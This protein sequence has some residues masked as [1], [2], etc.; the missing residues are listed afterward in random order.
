MRSSNSYP[1]LP[2]SGR[3]LVGGAI[4]LVV[5][6]HW[7]RRDGKAGAHAGTRGGGT[8]PAV[9]RRDDNVAIA[10]FDQRLT[11]DQELLGAFHDDPEFHEF[12]E[13]AAVGRRRR[14]NA[15]APDH[16]RRVVFVAHEATGLSTFDDVFLPVEV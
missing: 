5:R 4:S 3:S 6:A 13:V 16:V 9:D 8:M 12:V 11:L 2:W 7:T 14:R 10:G 1:S 15:F